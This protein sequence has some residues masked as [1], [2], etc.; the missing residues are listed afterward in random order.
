MVLSASN[1]SL[2]VRSLGL[3]LLGISLFWLSTLPFTTTA[4]STRPSEA[5]FAVTVV[6]SSV[7]IKV[8]EKISVNVTVT[9]A[10]ASP[11]GRICFSVQGF[12]DSGFRES[13]L[14]ECAT[15][16]S[17]RM[18][19]I[20]TVEVTAA[21]APQ[22]FTAFI[23]AHSEAQTAEATLDITVEP[24]FPPWIAWVGILLFLLILGV[25]I[26]GRPRLRI[27]IVRRL[28]G[29]RNALEMSSLSEPLGRNANKALTCRLVTLNSGLSCTLQLVLHLN[30]FL[31]LTLFVRRMV[32]DWA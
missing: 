7:V 31:G 13:F 9:G 5:G 20:L 22:S 10:E 4:Y 17:N 21:A 30:P 3:L 14:P 2:K 27:Q 8:G 24:A 1:A 6:P 18:A 19:A 11:I 12:P 23:V 32:F 16:Q 15:S 26:M 25:A 28:L 29:R